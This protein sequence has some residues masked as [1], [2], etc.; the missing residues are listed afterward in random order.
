MARQ[1][2]TQQANYLLCR[3]V[4]H[5]WDVVAADKLSRKGGVPVWLRC[6][7][8]GTERRDAVSPTTGEL[9]ARQYVYDTSYR[10]S[11]DSQFADAAPTKSDWRR[12]LLGERLIQAR[13][14]RALAQE[15]ADDASEQPGL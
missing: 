1:F 7:R 3:S 12:M 9:W 11:F 8:C 6:E 13:A 14:E 15:V 4:G 5:A 2:Y 10:H